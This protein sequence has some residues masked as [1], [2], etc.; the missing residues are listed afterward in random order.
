MR[1]RRP[2]FFALAIA[3]ATAQPATAHWTYCYPTGEAPAGVNV[4]PDYPPRP[5]SFERFVLPQT[6]KRLCGLPSAEETSYVRALISD[7][8]QCPAETPLARRIE[9]LLT[10]PTEEIFQSYFGTDGAPDSPHWD[11]VCDLA[12]KAS[13][14]TL[15]YGDG[16]YF[17]SPIAHE[18][19]GHIVALTQELKALS[20]SLEGKSDG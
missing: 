12:E 16:W 11:V 13:V 19:W 1:P 2:P 5:F 15:A 8:L 3:L 7:A 9:G 4:H 17:D 20:A 14:E 10:A 6:F 18:D